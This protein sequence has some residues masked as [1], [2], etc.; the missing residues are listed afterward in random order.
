MGRPHL[1]FEGVVPPVSPK[2][3]PI[4]SLSVCKYWSHTNISMSYRNMQLPPQYWSH[5]FHIFS[6]IGLIHSTFSQILVSY[7]PHFLKYWSHT[8]HIFSEQKTRNQLPGRTC[9]RHLIQAMSWIKLL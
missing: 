8:S 5:T 2:S 4:V 6:N 1:K 9:Y 7:I 3:L